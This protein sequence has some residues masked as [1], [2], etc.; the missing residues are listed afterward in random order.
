MDDQFN[1]EIVV[2][3]DKEKEDF[4]ARLKITIDAKTIEQAIIIAV[5]LL[6]KQHICQYYTVKKVRNNSVV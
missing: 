4:Y 6:E 2:Y 5:D 3:R 1:V